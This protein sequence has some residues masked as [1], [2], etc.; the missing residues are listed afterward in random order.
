V[1][2]FKYT[3]KKIRK[4]NKQIKFYRKCRK[5]TKRQ[6]MVHKNKQK[7]RIHN[8]KKHVNVV[9]PIRTKKVNIQMDD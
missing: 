2:I 9:L 5:G 3:A 1:D 4:L 7:M 6:T 8:E